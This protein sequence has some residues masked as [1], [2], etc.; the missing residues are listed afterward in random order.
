MSEN[1]YPFD[2]ASIDVQFNARPGSPV[3]AIISHRLRKPTLQELI[4]REKAINLEIVETSNREEQIVTDDDAANC[5]L[6]DRLIVEVKGYAGVTDWQSL[7]DSQKAQMRPGHKRTAI[8]AMYAGSAQ[9]VGGED[10]EI[11][12][13]MDSWTIRQLVGPDAENPI[14]TIDHVLREPTESERAKFKRNASKVSFVRGAK[15]PRTKI[16]ADL[17]AYVEIYDALVTSIDG[18]TVAGKTLAESDRTAFL[19][20]I[21][22]TWKR[23]IVQTLMNAIEAALLD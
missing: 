14:Y 1:A 11:S 15:R 16:G 21:D 23:V 2:A 19:A 10:D 13:A 18:G 22:P 9:V 7:T 4:D 3:P 8:V 12:L 5:Q 20:A 17:R 6:W